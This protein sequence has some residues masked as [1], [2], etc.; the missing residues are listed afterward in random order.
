ML[1][2]EVDIVQRA[3]NKVLYPKQ[4]LFQDAVKPLWDKFLCTKDDADMAIGELIRQI[5]EIE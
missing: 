2:V 4:K 1:A 3:G 5:R